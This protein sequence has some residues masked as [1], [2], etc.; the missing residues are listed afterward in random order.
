MVHNVK[1]VLPLKDNLDKIIEREYKNAFEILDELDILK[2]IEDNCVTIESNYKTKYIK[3]K[4]KILEDKHSFKA[5]YSPTKNKIVFSKG[6]IRSDIDRQYFLIKYF[7]YKEDIERLINRPLKD[8]GYK[9]IKDIEYLN[10]SIDSKILLY[11]SYINERNMIESIAESIT[12]LAMYHE[13]W[14]SIDRYILLKLVKDSTIKN[15]YYLLTILNDRDNIELRA[16][17]FEAIM[18]YLVNGFHKDERGYMAAYFNIPKCREYIEEINMLE[19]YG[20]INL[21]SPYNIGFCYGNIIVAKYGPS[22]KENIYKV[23]NDIIHLDEKRAIDE[24]KLYGDNLEW[25]SND[26]NS[27]SVI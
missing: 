13:I 27:N 15:R 17:D 11:P 6:S 16:S 12:R 14:H 8:L 3:P 7:S 25:I 9:E 2:Y 24:I 18:Y 26:K 5:K 4:L 20:Y 21:G 23:I 22:L 1:K 19:N 10:N